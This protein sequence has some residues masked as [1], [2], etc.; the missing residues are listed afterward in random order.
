MTGDQVVSQ[1][2]CPGSVDADRAARPVTRR[3]I[4]A[5]AALVAATVRG[6]YPAL[7]GPTA[8]PASPTILV[9]GPPGSYVDQWAALIT[10]PLGKSLL[11]GEAIGRENIGG[12]DGVTGANHFQASTPPDGGTAM[13]IPG[14]AALSWLVGDPR[15][16][17][18]AGNW[19]P[20]WGGTT[21]VLA[22]TRVAL[23]RGRSVRVAVQTLVGPE[24]AVLLALELMG[25]EA[26]AVP[27][28][29]GAATS[30]DRPDIDLVVLRGPEL[31]QL[32]PELAARRWT[33]AFTLGMIGA[34]GRVVRN[35]AMADAPTALELIDRDAAVP[36]GRAGLERFS[37]LSSALRAVTA[38]AMLDFALVVPLLAPAAVVAW[39]RQGCI[40]LASAPELQEAATKRLVRPAE[41]GAVVASMSAITADPT[42]LLELRR[43]LEERHHWRPA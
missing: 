10:G 11:L 40:G 35:P 28:G 31:K 39:W 4:L 7:A 5:S 26:V 41:T 43:W 3:A 38:A 34:D 29:A 8:L 20:L 18:D 1:A 23:A 25:I 12:P 2:G 42:A 16:R 14:A 6:R 13:I 24:L 30:F 19:V 21:P 22:V 27:V 36:P 33:H 17:F 32:A 9:A 37:E 15:V